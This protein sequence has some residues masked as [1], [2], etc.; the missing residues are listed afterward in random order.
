MRMGNSM[1]K[2]IT[3]LLLV[4]SISTLA[5]AQVSTMNGFRRGFAIAAFA[6]IGGAVLGLS[7][8]S[9]YGS[10]QEHTSNITTGFFLGVAGG[11]GYVVMESAQNS[12]RP[13]YESYGLLENSRNH[14]P[15]FRGVVLPVY[16]AEF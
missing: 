16:V 3:V 2:I 12:A 4:V 7:T 6:G 9:F 13:T 14:K 1:R 11:L 10:P 8:L 15:A 5:Q